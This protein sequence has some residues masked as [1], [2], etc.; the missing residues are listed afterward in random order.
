M[1]HRVEIGG[2]VHTW[3]DQKA[4]DISI[5]IFPDHR[6]PNCFYAPLFEVAP[7][8]S[9]DFVG[10]TTEGGPVNFLNFRINPH[11]N[12][13]HTECVGHI[14]QGGESINKTLKQFFSIA[15]LVTIYPEKA[16][17]GDKIITLAQLKGALS[18][19]KCESLVI[20]T[21]PNHPDKKVRNYSGTNPAY[22]SEK[23]MRWIV[24]LGV[25]HLL[26][27]LPSVDPEVDGGKLLA[28]RAFWDDSA[29]DRSKCT[30]T[31]LI[32]IDNNIKD[33][34]YLLNIQIGSFELDVS[35]SKPVL[36]VLEKEI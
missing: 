17:N 8:R 16:K 28:H 12:G 24:E 36:Y 20:R 32:Y 1:K 21:M 14:S 33:D 4:I 27:D 11:G 35:P 15:H 29:T 13:T 18:V 10:S 3:D 5:P 7:V 26:I 19:H 22:L 34:L 6:Q 30:I 25:Q 23:A 2:I 31:E 9:G